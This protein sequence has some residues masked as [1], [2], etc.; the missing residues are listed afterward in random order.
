MFVCWNVFACMQAL[1]SLLWLAVV[2]LAL[3]VQAESIAGGLFLL[4]Q[5]F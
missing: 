3:L 4:F 2:M 5:R 1:T